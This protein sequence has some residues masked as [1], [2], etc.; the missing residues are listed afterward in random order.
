[1]VQE[2]QRAIGQDQGRQ[3]AGR[4]DLR[5]RDERHRAW[6]RVGPRPQAVRLQP[7]DQPEHQGHLQ[8]EV[9]TLAAEAES[10]GRPGQIMFITRAS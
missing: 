8:D 10:Q 3:S 1:M 5:G 9:H 4:E 2:V 6:D 7:K